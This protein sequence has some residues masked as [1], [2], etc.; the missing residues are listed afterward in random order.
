LLSPVTAE[1]DTFLIGNNK[2]FIISESELMKIPEF[3][4]L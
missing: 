4:D 2:I 1:I 3:M